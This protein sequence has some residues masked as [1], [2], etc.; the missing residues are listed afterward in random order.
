MNPT[1]GKA[2]IKPIHPKAAPARGVG[3]IKITPKLTRLILLGLLG[4]L[5]I[6]FLVIASAGL[7][8]LSQK[9]QQLVSAKLKSRTVDN[10]LTSLQLAKKQIDKY[11]YF[12]DV[13]KTVIPNDKDQAQAV[14]DISQQAAQAGI[15]IASITFPA[16]TLG[17]SSK[18]VSA[19]GSS[20]TSTAISQAVPVTGIK[21]LYS[22]ELTIIP[23]TGPTVPANQVVTYPKFLDFLNRIEHDR[24]TAQIT[25]V[26]IQ[27]V[28]TNSGP[29]GEINFSLTVNIFIRPTQ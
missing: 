3:G 20:S 6:I 7:G 19:T 15:S 16:S 1:W 26:G 25:Q 27:P 28:S 8:K 21:G 9:S 10:Q 29:T 12:N 17:G 14:L 24:R 2:P 11:A 23:L 18:A 4:I 22:L 5:V 13:A